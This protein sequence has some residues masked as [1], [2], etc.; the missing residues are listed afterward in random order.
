MFFWAA[1]S[2]QAQPPE[3]GY[4]WDCW[5]TQEPS[6]QISCIRDRGEP[7]L[8]PSDRLE[9]EDL[10]EILLDHIHYRL[11]NDEDMAALSE[12]VN[13]NFKVFQR[14]SIWSITLH[15]PP[16]ESSWQEGR[17]QMLVRSLLCPGHLPCTV[18]IKGAPQAAPPQKTLKRRRR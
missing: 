14:G 1:A 13:S 2:A 17:P 7:Q 6:T 3:P 9:D 4:A 16:Y 15:T 8:H 10:E 11:H 18:T 12:L 5:V